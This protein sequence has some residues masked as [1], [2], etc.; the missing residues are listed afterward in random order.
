MAGHGV[1]GEE[2]VVGEVGELVLA[3]GEGLAGVA[4]RGL[5]ELHVGTVYMEPPEVRSFSS[6]V[7]YDRP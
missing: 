4:V 7:G 3:A 1:H 6:A 2:L 5:D